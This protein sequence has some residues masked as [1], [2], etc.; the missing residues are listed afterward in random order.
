MLTKARTG[1]LINTLAPL[2]KSCINDLSLVLCLRLFS[3][4]EG[5]LSMN[6][7]PMNE[8]TAVVYAGNEIFR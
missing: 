8:T 1:V 5:S 2:V 3:G 4:I 6:K 7:N